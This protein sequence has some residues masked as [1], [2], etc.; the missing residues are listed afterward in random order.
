[1][2]R[3]TYHYYHTVKTCTPNLEIFFSFS[4]LCSI[5]FNEPLSH[6]LRHLSPFKQLRK[7]KLSKVPC[8]DVHIMTEQIGIQLLH[9]E[10]VCLRES[11]DLTQVAIQC[12]NLQTLE[13]YYSMAVHVSSPINFQF[14]HLQKLI[15]YST[16]ILGPDAQQVSINLKR[17]KAIPIL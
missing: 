4:E 10:L 13:V 6:L 7:I 2:G 11:L 9:L 16:D 5:Y 17:A 3:L 15:I 8:Y 12:P 1:M 14:R